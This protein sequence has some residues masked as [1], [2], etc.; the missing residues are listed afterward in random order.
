VNIIG[1]KAEVKFR[2]SALTSFEGDYIKFFRPEDHR[3]GSKSIDKLLHMRV[4]GR[5][6]L[7]IINSST[8]GKPFYHQLEHKYNII[9]EDWCTW[10][11][12][13]TLNG[14][15]K[16][17][18]QYSPVNPS[19]SF[20]S[21]NHRPREKRCHFIDKLSE[22]GLIDKNYVTWQGYETS[23]NFK[24]FDNRK[25]V[26]DNE[27]LTNTHTSKVPFDMFHPPKKAFIDSLWSVVCE[28]MMDE[29]P[30]RTYTLTEKVMVPIAHKKP[31]IIFG[32]SSIYKNYEELGFELYDEIIDYS[33]VSISS[34]DKR[35]EAFMDQ[36]IKISKLDPAKTHEQ[37]KPKIDRNF[38]R[39]IDIVR[40]RVMSINDKIATQE[41]I[42][43]MQT[44]I[45][46]KCGEIKL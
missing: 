14:L 45:R 17:G 30:D 18:E 37:L 10:H 1:Y 31:L 22:T 33:Y 2:E 36:V 4:Q 24:H 44:L 19:K 40:N 46:N 16:I 35:L 3:I 26:L 23:F 21:L 25:L 39:L 38:K 15:L 41:H 29:N 8:V 11:A 42:K 12:Y 7:H 5:P 27:Y 13:E 28:Y 20:C 9:Y 34:F 43:D 6:T 32:G